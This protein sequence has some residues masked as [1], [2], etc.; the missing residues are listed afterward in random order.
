MTAVS[1]RGMRRSVDGAMLCQSKVVADTMIITATRAAIGICAT[2]SPIP[3]TRASRKTPV[4]KVEIRV[5]APAVFT[6]TIV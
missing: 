6:L 2:M 4:R 3:T 1:L 5:R